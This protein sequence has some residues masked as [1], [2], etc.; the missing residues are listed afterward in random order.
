MIP[1]GSNFITDPLWSSG[2]TQI[3]HDGA[4]SRRND[5]IK[6]IAENSNALSILRV[7]WQDKGY[8][9]GQ[10]SKCLRTM[11]ALREMEKNNHPR[12]SLSLNNL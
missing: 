1:D 10:C 9:C 7:C 5:K 4:D 3:I 2:Y 11:V 12:N 6:F 8:N